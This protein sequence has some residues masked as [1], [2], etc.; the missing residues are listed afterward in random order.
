MKKIFI[1]ILLVLSL[2]SCSHGSQSQSA[3]FSKKDIKIVSPSGAPCLAL[4]NYI[5]SNQVT[6][7]TVPA[8]VMAQLLTNNYDVIVSEFYNGLKSVNKNNADYFLARIITGGNLYLVGINK[9]SGDSP[10]EGD[11]VVSF[12]QNSIPD[13]TYKAI[14]GQM[15]ATVE[16]VASN[17]EIIPVLKN[18]THAGNKV[19]YVV[20][21]E[22]ALTTVMKSLNN[23]VYT[24]VSLR[25][26]YGEK[27]NDDPYIP[28]A[29]LFINKTQYNRYKAIFDSF[30]DDLVNDIDIAISD[31]VKVK[32][33]MDF[34][35]LDEQK[36]LFSFNSNIM[37]DIQQS[38]GFGLVG[39]K[40]KI[41]IDNFLK[42]ILGEKYDR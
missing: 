29:G 13:L 28:Q 3:I 2:T 11:Y 20:I 25:E 27:F 4:Y 14:Y 8:N 9:N 42:N 34:Y 18:G 17:S 21:A 38:N 35:T 41:D 30:I 5:S 12:N 39:S 7:N 6:V 37:M 26:Q 1:P 36:I 15:G 16:Y 23:D 22:P 31:P 10:K 19:D 32:E 24:F 40:T 33:K